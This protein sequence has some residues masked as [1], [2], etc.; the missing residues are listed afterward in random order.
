MAESIDYIAR[1]YKVPTVKPNVERKILLGIVLVCALIISYVIISHTF[2]STVPRRVLAPS[3]SPVSISD[4]FLHHLNK[5]TERYTMEQLDLS[6]HTADSEEVK[7]THVAMNEDH[8]GFYTSARIIHQ[9]S[10]RQG[11]Y[12]LN[13]RT[14]N[15]VPHKVQGSIQVGREESDV[16]VYLLE[17]SEKEKTLCVFSQEEM[18]QEFSRVPGSRRRWG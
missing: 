2:S 4:S 14:N 9:Q 15:W 18:R 3:S 10:R 11:L 17:C 1:I 7:C 5:G 6:V 12:P 16:E 8:I 13:C